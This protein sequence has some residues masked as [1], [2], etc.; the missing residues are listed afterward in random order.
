MKI[1]RSENFI[2]FSFPSTRVE[3]SDKSRDDFHV[4]GNLQRAELTQ[5]NIRRILDIDL[6]GV[7]EH[8]E[9]NYVHSFQFFYY[10]E[11]DPRVSGLRPG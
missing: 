1:I 10:F 9:I 6:Q 4:L 11:C 8:E 5:F 2:K 7:A 3:V